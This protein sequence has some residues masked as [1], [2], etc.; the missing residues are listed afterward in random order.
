MDSLKKINI[1][2]YK[3]NNFLHSMTSQNLQPSS[4]YSSA[5]KD[6]F[7]MPSIYNQSKKCIECDNLGLKLWI[8]CA[9]KRECKIEGI[10]LDFIFLLII[11][12]ITYICI[13]SF[14]HFHPG[15]WINSIS[16]WCFTRLSTRKRNGE[17][18]E[19]IFE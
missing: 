16:D 3:T 8:N 1:R 6:T 17:K 9:I 10:A 14:N 12:Y 5:L 2:Y 11:Q 19:E 15:K 7:Q 18:R 13:A 4:M